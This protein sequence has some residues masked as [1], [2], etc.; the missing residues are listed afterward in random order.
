MKLNNKGFAISTIIYSI[1]VLFLMFLFGILAV[2][3][4]RKIVL[5]KLRTDVMNQLNSDIVNNDY[6]DSSGANKPLLLDNMIPIK[7][8]GTNWIYADKTSEWYNYDNKQWANAVVLSG[9]VTKEVGNTISED[10]IALWYVW[11][12]RYKY[13]IFNGNNGSVEEKLINISFERGIRTTGTVRCTDAISGINTNNSEDCAD[14]IN[15]NIIDGTSTYTHPAFT[16]GS[17]EL[18]GIWVGKFE[19]S[20]ST[21]KITIKPN[22]S[23]LRNK[24]VSEFF[25]SIRDIE[26]DYGIENG[27][28]HMMK[29]MEWGLVA[30][31]KQSKYGLGT[32]DIWINNNNSYKTGCAGNSFNA[33]SSSSCN[34]YLTDNGVK[35]STTG[36]MYGVYDMSGGAYEYV[37]GNMVNA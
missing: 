35:A 31:F 11:V 24:T 22:T 21:S 1:L 37:M 12:P 29:N 10:D 2:L 27:N 9:G 33:S 25:S 3:G 19:N 4:N 18:T 30:Y 28:S 14:N 15:G 16:F 23:S 17:D 32:K 36:N 20:G 13:T 7:Y 5:D 8:D 26:G 6:I 34:E